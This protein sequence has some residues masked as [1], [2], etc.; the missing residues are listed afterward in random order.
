MMGQKM[1][2]NKK[3]WPSIKDDQIESDQQRMI[4]PKDNRQLTKDGQPKR[5]SAIN[6]EESTRDD[7]LIII[8][9]KE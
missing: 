8:L 9:S 4:N 2:D 6:K 5:W 3:D 1:I 7:W